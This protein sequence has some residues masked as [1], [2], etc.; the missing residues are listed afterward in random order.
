MDGRQIK[1]IKAHVVNVWQAADHVVEGA[2]PVRAIRR[3]TR[4]QLVPGGELRL[5]SL[6]LE[7]QRRLVPMCR[8]A[9]SS[10]PRMTSSRSRDRRMSALDSTDVSVQPIERRGDDLAATRCARACARSE[11]LA[12]FGDVDIDVGAGLAFEIEVPAKR[13]V[14]VPPRLDGESITPDAVR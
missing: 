2:M 3:G 12:A 14:S 7:R 4:E 9:R 8:K 10:A 13:A 11:K 1:N 6:D 5:W